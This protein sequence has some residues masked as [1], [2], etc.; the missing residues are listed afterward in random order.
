MI[1]ASTFRFNNTTHSTTL[2]GAV[3][4]AIA[5]ACA[6]AV[7]APL[8]A[9]SA[10][11]NEKKNE[12]PWNVSVGLF[13]VT[14]PEYEGG[15]RRVTSALPD[16]NISYRTDNWGT[17]GAGSKSRGVSWTVIDK[18][19]YSFG[20]ALGGDAG[21]SEKDGTGF[22]P[23]GKRLRGLGEIKASAEF[24]VFGHVMAGIPIHLQIMKGAGDGK[25]DGKDFSFKGHGGTHA[26]LG[27]EIPLELTKEL[28]LSFSAGVNWADKKYTQTYFGVTAAQAARSGFR[29]YNV[30]GGVKSVDIGVAL[31][32]KIDKNWSATAGL[33]YSQLQGDAAK[34][35]VTEKKGQPSA[36][37]GVNYTF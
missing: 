31:N 34:S 5:A 13:A 21:R 32:Y 20:V 36:L 25:P 6:M 26:H 1:N 7:S 22:R 18:E 33:T 9:Q 11:A 8:Y 17:F 37:I 24:G 2:R 16:L 15:K 35:P 4:A 23:G 29:Q 28:G 14:A 12:G 19:Q 27:T 30:K 3:M 10:P